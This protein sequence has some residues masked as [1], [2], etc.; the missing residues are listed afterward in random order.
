MAKRLNTQL[1]DEELITIE[2]AIRHDERARVRQRATAIHMLH[3]GKSPGEV[4]EVMAVTRAT[5]YNWHSRFRAEG[6]AGLVNRPRSGR[7][8]V[9]DDEEYCR[10]LAETIDKEPP[11]LGYAFNIWTINRLRNH[12]EKETGKSLSYERF[13]LLL[14]EKG[15]RYRRPKHDL[16]HLQDQEAK[17][18]ARQ[19]L[20]E[21]KK[22]SGET[23]SSSSLWTKRP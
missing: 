11:D 13:R 3:L 1:T 19:L 15:Y 22:G 14:K 10:V 16:H 20:E 21:L 7:P 5:V 18:Q 9:A 12:L 6:L 23:K 17:E 8:S 2:Q 4:A